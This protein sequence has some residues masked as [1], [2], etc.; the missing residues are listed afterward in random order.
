MLPAGGSWL[1]D[2][3]QDA[4]SQHRSTF[5]LPNS[6]RL[7]PIDI[8][9]IETIADCRSISAAVSIQDLAD[10]RR[11]TSRAVETFPGRR[12]AGR[13]RSRPRAPR[14]SG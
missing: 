6:G 10:G 9:L 11:P 2:T 5:A 14:M 7:E 4:L 13:E 12:L 1:N 8:Q 3:T